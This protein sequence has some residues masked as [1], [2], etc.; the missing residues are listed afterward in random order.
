MESNIRD[1]EGML[2]GTLSAADTLQ[3]ILSSESSL[4][5]ELTIPMIADPPPIY[6]GEYTVIP[7]EEEQIL[8]TM[9]CLLLDNITINPIPTNYGKVTWTSGH[10]L[11]E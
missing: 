3:G 11:I 4:T 5:A 6:T 7:T 2:I 9:G 10:L 1:S 8:P